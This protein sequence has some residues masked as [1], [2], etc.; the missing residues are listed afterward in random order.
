MKLSRRQFMATLALSSL[1]ARRVLAGVTSSSTSLSSVKACSW[2]ADLQPQTIAGHH[3]PFPGGRG[4]FSAVGCSSAH[5]EPLFFG[6]RR[7][8][9]R[10]RDNPNPRGPD[11]VQ[12]P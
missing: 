7:G 4:D 5:A 10:A 2:K 1:G 3:G 8:R 11:D 6:K 9:A 12:T